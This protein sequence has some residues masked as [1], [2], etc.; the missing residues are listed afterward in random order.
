MNEPQTAPAANSNDAFAAAAANYRQQHAE[1]TQ[2]LNTL[3]Q[4]YV[5]KKNQ[6]QSTL[7]MLAGAVAAVEQIIKNVADEVAASVVRAVEA[8]KNTVVDGPLS[9]AAVDALLMS[10]SPIGCDIPF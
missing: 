6:L 1:A 8:D 10:D 7:L 2:Q 9:E 5:T 3:E 4:D